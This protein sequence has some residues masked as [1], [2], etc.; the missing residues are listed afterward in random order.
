MKNTN[1]YY[2][3]VTKISFSF[4]LFAHETQSDQFFSSNF[5]RCRV[6]HVRSL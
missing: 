2:A 6:R 3:K 4:S 1:I 5:Y